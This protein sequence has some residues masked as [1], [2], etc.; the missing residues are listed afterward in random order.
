MDILLILIAFAHVAIFVSR[1]GIPLMVAPS[2]SCYVAPRALVFPLLAVSLLVGTL[3]LAGDV[4]FGVEVDARALFVCFTAA[5][6]AYAICRA[7][8]PHI[9]RLY[10]VVVAFVGRSFLLHEGT[11]FGWHDFLGWIVSPVIAFV[12]A[13]LIFNALSALLRDAN[14]RYLSFLQA[15]GCAISGATLL[16]FMAVGINLGGVLTMEAFTPWS[17]AVLGCAVL[18]AGYR[19]MTLISVL[20]EREFD[21]NPMVAL[22]TLLSTTAVILFFSFDATASLIGIKPTIISPVVLLFASLLG[23]SRSQRRSAM[24]GDEFVRICV[25]NIVALIISLT[26]GYLLSALLVGDFVGGSDLKSILLSLAIVVVVLLALIT[27]QNR[28]K[29]HQRALLAREQAE[30]L[31]ANRRSLNR[32]EVEA[33]QAEN[34]NL[35][36]QL[37]LKRKEVISVAMN[38]TEQ[39]EFIHHLYEELKQIRKVEDAAEKDRMLDKL[40]TDLS[41]RMNFTSEIDSFYTQVEQLHKDFGVRLTEKFPDLTRQERRL[42]IL[43]RLDFSTKYIA[44]LMN[45]SPKSV[46][47]SRHRL[48]AKLGLKREQNLTNFIKTI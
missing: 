9:S 25:V 48:R 10:L 19:K 12:L 26:L 28:R 24:S 21:I 6:A 30:L 27:L 47:I 38:I 3:F 22:A 17:L 20:R 43:L 36:N 31:E 5:L 14:I 37:E 40:H 44:T 34:D 2:A 23:C 8:T 46:E 42:V 45:I 4:S 39:K 7:I 29:S 1:G 15:M 13:V 16:L 41:L 11:T 35:R 33:M 32:L 18:L